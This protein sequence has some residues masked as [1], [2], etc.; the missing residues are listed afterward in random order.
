MGSFLAPASTVLGELTV[1]AVEAE[2]LLLRSRKAGAQRAL[3]L[4]RPPLGQ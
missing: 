3:A 4:G 1:C 2:G